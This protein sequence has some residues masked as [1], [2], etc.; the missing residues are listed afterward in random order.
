M[1]VVCIQRIRTTTMLAC[2]HAV[3]SDEL[4][5]LAGRNGFWGRGWGRC[6]SA[7]SAD[8]DFKS[9]ESVPEEKSCHCGVG[10]Q[11]QRC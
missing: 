10:H 11:A 1:V 6:R 9:V 7:G 2:D 8:D 4:G 3:Y 5:F